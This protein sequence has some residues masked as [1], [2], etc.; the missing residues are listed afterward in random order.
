MRLQ[1]RQPLDYVAYEQ[2][3][4]KHERFLEDTKEILQALD[5]HYVYQYIEK[6][7]EFYKMKK[8]LLD[9]IEQVGKTIHMIDKGLHQFTT[10]TSRADLIHMNLAYGYKTAYHEYLNTARYSTQQDENDIDNYIDSKPFEHSKAHDKAIDDTKH[11]E[12]QSTKLDYKETVEE[13]SKRMLDSIRNARYKSDEEVKRERAEKERDEQ[14][15]KEHKA[16][17]DKKFNE[18]TKDTGVVW[19]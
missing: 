13:N 10:K 6:P 9:D 2:I 14:V 4:K 12:E 16:E 5:T 15:K 7:N 19:K 8:A 17:L 11:D 18:L 3:K 1:Q